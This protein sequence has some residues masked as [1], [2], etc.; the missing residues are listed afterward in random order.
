MVKTYDSK[1][2]L[3]ICGPYPLEGFADGARISVSR[4]EDMWTD[5]AGS[6]GEGARAKSN[7]KR[8]TVTVTL[9]QTS[10]SNAILSA[11]AAADEVSNAGVFPLYIKDKNGTSLYVAESAW[12]KKYS[13][14]GF[15][16][17]VGEREWII[18]TDNLVMYTGGTE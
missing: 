4:N 7:D 17:E 16:E 6:D 15:A 8:G 18:A 12:V 9:M 13:D 2:V 5:Y 14:A 1:Q 11:Y 3:V 10:Q